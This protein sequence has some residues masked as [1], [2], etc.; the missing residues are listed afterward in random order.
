MTHTEKQKSLL[1][2][3]TKTAAPHEVV[4]L[5]VS[6][7]P[8]QKGVELHHQTPLPPPW[9]ESA[10]ADSK[11]TPTNRVSTDSD[12]GCSSRWCTNRSRQKTTRLQRRENIRSAAYGAAETPRN[13]GRI[14]ENS[15]P[16]NQRKVHLPQS[17]NGQGRG[18]VD[19]NSARRPPE[20]RNRV[21]QAP[22]KEPCVSSRGPQGPSTR[23]A[24]WNP[25]Q[26]C[27]DGKGEDRNRVP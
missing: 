2:K 22:K 14:R 19:P 21:P 15:A 16:R 4:V 1:R 6:R 17:T 12:T 3:Q 18:S 7:L 9:R 20:K 24:P 13:L 10:L 25:A 27:W 23:A 11:P 8:A 5:T 26:L